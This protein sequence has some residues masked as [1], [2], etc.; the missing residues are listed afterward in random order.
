VL[1]AIGGPPTVP[2]INNNPE[3]ISQALQQ[4]YNG[5]VS[6]TYSEPSTRWHNGHT[7]SFNNRLGT[8]RLSRNHWTNL[9][10]APLMQPLQSTST[11]TDTRM[12]RR[13]YL[14]RP[15][16]CPK[17]A[18]HQPVALRNQLN[19][20]ERQRTN[21]RHH[22]WRAVAPPPTRST[23]NGL[24]HTVTGA[25]QPPVNHTAN[26]PDPGHRGRRDCHHHPERTCHRSSGAPD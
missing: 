17:Q 15:T 14:P 11:I 24:A 18:D 25:Q 9:R 4:F 1:A 19:P 13:G 6:P 12:R 5:K 23:R 3:L 8:E 16:T 20:D 26:L 22:H 21:R 7:K 10:Q 2:G